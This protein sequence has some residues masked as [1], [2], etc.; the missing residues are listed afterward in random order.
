MN[1]ELK[2]NVKFTSFIVHTVGVD[3]PTRGVQLAASPAMEYA[4]IV[5]AAS[6][7]QA[8]PVKASP[9]LASPVKPS[10]V[11][12]SP[13]KASSAPVIK[14]TTN[15]QCGASV[16]AKCDVA[17]TYP[18]CSDG[19]CGN[20]GPAASP[21]VVKAAVVQPSAAPSVAPS[22]VKA[23]PGASAKPAVS[24]QPSPTYPCGSQQNVLYFGVCYK[25]G[26]VNT[27]GWTW[28]TSGWT[29]NAPSC[30][31]PDGNLG[32]YCFSSGMSAANY[33]CSNG[34]L[35]N[36]TTSNR[37][38]AAATTTVS[39]AALSPAPL[40]TTVILSS[41]IPST[42]PSSTVIPSIF[43]SAAPSKTIIS[44]VLPSAA[45][46]TTI[47]PSALASTALSTTLDPSLDP[48]KQ[49]TP[50]EGPTTTMTPSAEASSFV[51]SS[52]T[53]TAQS[54]AFSTFI[55]P[56][57]TIA[58]KIIAPSAAPSAAP[59][60]VCGSVNNVL[61]NGV[62]YSP[63]QV[64]T[65][66]WTWSL[67]GWQCPTP[68]CPVPSG[69][70]QGYCIASGSTQ[71]TNYI[72]SNGVFSLTPLKTYTPACANICGCRTIS[73]G[74]NWVYRDTTIDGTKLFKNGQP[75]RFVSVNYQDI[76]QS[77]DVYSTNGGGY[78]QGEGP[79]AYMGWPDAWEVEDGI[80]TVAGFGG[81]VIR[82]YT[83]SIWDPNNGGCNGA[84]NDYFA[85]KAPGL[86]SE[87]YFQSMDRAI[88]LAS[89][90]GVHL[91]FP[92]IDYWWWRGG[93]R[94]FASHRVANANRVDFYTNR[95]VIQDFE[96][97]LYYILH[98]V[99]TV[100]GVA[101]KDDPTILAWEL[102]NEGGGWS[103]VYDPTWA[104]TIAQF[105]K[106]IDPNHLI[107]DGSYNNGGYY[108]GST[109]WEYLKVQGVLS[110]PCI[111]IMS[112]HYYAVQ[113]QSDFPARIAQDVAYTKSVNKP[114]IVDEWA[115]WTGSVT[116]SWI[117]TF[118]TSVQNTPG[119]AGVLLWSL[120]SH[121][122]SGGWYQHYEYPSP[123][124]DYHFPGFTS[125]ISTFDE[126]FVCSNIMQYAASI[127]GKTLSL[128]LPSAPGIISGITSKTLRWQGSVLA[129]YYKVFSAPPSNVTSWTLIGKNVVDTLPPGSTLFTDPVS[130]PAGQ[131]RLY[132]FQ[133]CNTGGCGANSTVI[134]AKLG[135][136][137]QVEIREI[138]DTDTDNSIRFVLSKTDLALANAIRR[139]CIAEVS[140]IAI[141]LVN[142][143]VNTT[144]LSDEFIAHRL[145][146]I[147]LN[148]ESVHELKPNRDCGCDGYCNQCSITLTLN[149]SFN[150]G[151]KDTMI[152]TSDDLRTG[153][154]KGRGAPSKRAGEDPISIVKLKKGQQ[155]WLT[156]IARKGIGKEHSKWSPCG[157]VSFDYD[158]WNKL[159]HSVY[160]YE[161]S[162]EVD[163]PA[164]DPDRF[165]NA[166][167]FEER[168]PQPDEPFDYNATAN[169][170]YMTVESTGAIPPERIVIDALKG[171]ADKLDDLKLA[172]DRVGNRQGEG[173]GGEGMQ[174][175]ADYAY[176]PPPPTTP[177][178]YTNM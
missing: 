110:N 20:I 107:M 92:I 1:C 147:P 73:P 108:G 138:V 149:V 120:V 142:F 81:A 159:R 153:D 150:T 118:L 141:D 116:S 18:C 104:Q 106:T 146:M 2:F 57:V 164:P 161:E 54:P 8:S 13:V 36:V 123:F 85:Y 56:S 102:L 151:D 21:V 174:T 137:P 173:E 134:T 115:I 101:Y 40:T 63:G 170:F 39:S 88:A 30:P 50:S 5:V 103:D 122:V 4:K 125:S 117:S 154:P 98:R 156:C 80:A 19:L 168:K 6:P 72:C 71:Y 112:N 7:V 33:S 64:N 160:W 158:P 113:S 94:A 9:V 68:K 140:T 90:Y 97:F 148:S 41:I 3:Q 46:S 152:V 100:T 77:V 65:F 31:I 126:G 109:K 26:D 37:L 105:I 43:A 176:H 114:L 135:S 136:R 132:K 87:T 48:S 53:T 83:F 75:F 61:Y 58:A 44:S 163:W 24:V 12:P 145:G 70:Y 49:I 15:S 89:K 27:I 69:Q 55:T 78:C 47:I 51:L 143:I 11:L 74:A 131:T 91:I 171:L 32:G 45:P 172:V 67:Q 35:T 34:V 121:H 62:C 119:V 14:L 166:P 124:T 99:N 59:S 133:G 169:K 10:P 16:S 52:P 28:T 22:P 29:C 95:Q 17:G 175:E 82:A 86:Y 139:T 23:S 162:P 127:M 155:I 157:A 66:G 60:P 165:P 178:F 130:C 76:V 42:L 128:P 111:D 177:R 96:D 79:A 167:H 93:M 38:V 129:Q 84:Q 144:V 25:P